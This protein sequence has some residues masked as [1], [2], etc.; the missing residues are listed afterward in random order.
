MRA[1][2]LSTSTVGIYMRNLRTIYNQAIEK[3]LVPQEL[4]LFGKN[5]YS[6]PSSKKAKKSL[7]IDEIG[8]IFSYEPASETKGRGDQT[9]FGF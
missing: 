1:D 9:P 5:N 7:T 2:G 3:K 4:Y 8:K 6:P